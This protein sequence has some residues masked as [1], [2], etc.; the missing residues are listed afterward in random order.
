[1][2]PF[3][4]RIKKF[5]LTPKNL[6]LLGFLC[7]FALTFLDV[8]RGRHFNFLI[9]HDS[10]IDF[11]RHINPYGAEWAAAHHDYFLY[12]PLFSVLFAP[13]AFLPDWLGPF[14]WNLF[15]YSLYFAAVFTLPD[16]YTLDQ[17]CRMFLYTF[18]ILATTLYSFQYN[19]AV[20][21]LFVFAFSLLERGRAFWAVV[22]I[23]VSGFTKVYGIFE[24]GLLLCYPRFWRNMGYVLVVS[25]LFFLL[26]LLNLHYSELLPYYQSWV[27]GLTQH[28]DTRTW[29]TIFF[30]R[31]FF[32]GMP[33]YGMWIQIGA[34][35]ALAGLLIANFRR[36][37]QFVFRVQSL[38]VLMGWVILFSNSAEKHTY[39]IALLG[40]LLWYW[41]RRPQT[42]DK[43]LF[44]ANFIVLV[45]VPVDLICPPRVMLFLTETLQ[46]NL[47]LFIVTWG[48]MCYVTF[49]RDS[50]VAEL[51]S[52]GCAS[53][54]DEH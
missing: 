17:K 52:G 4:L 54:S 36:W 37:G 49:L 8:S 27:D 35:T 23:L 26:P 3:A 14:V 39:V 30:L 15:N 44:W 25:L 33:S 46:L 42:I 48:R 45:I 53:N 43:V 6:Y 2:T 1:M 47:W 38:A 5:F 19:V 12:G 20:A 21:Y 40:Y 13:F 29:Q 51:P 41:S 7:V 31:P 32:H 24:L 50:S 22:L 34:I 9:F 28:K 16:K 18:L 10:T 11:W